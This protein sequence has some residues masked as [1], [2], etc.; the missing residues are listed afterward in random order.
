VTAS[1]ETLARPTPSPT[2]A[3]LGRVEVVVNPAAGSVGPEAAGDA[4]RLMAEFGVAA[5]VSAPE[6]DELYMTLRA[7][8]ETGPDLLVVL[9][10]DGTARAAASLCGADGP[11]LAPL[12]GGTMNMLPHALYGKVDWREALRLALARG[13]AVPVSGGEVDDRRFYVAAILGAPALWAEAREA[14]RHGQLGLALRKARNAWARAFSGQLKFTLD[15]APPRKAE[16]LTL[17]CPLVSRAM[18]VDERALE[19]DVLN[20]RGAAEAFR[21]GFHA[22]LSEFAGDWRADPAV[23]VT[24]CR[25]GEAFA[26]GHIPAILD[27]EPARLHKHAEIRFVPLAFRALAP[28]PPEPEPAG[29]VLAPSVL[30]T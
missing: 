16:A 1:D 8:V 7:A 5:K 9:A 11:L 6:P 22:L 26:S 30:G 19:A 4:I 28:A 20:P 13:A 2:V 14:V 27:G 21:L 10:G 12:P 3:A 24:R 23:D 15:G 29:E 18:S 17:M 25:R